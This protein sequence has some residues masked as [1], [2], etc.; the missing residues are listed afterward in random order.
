MASSCIPLQSI[1]HPIILNFN[2]FKTITVKIGVN[3][4]RELGA[5]FLLCACQPSIARAT[6]LGRWVR[7]RGARRVG[8]AE[9]EEGVHQ[10]R[11]RQPLPHLRV[12][13]LKTG[14]DDPLV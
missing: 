5:V 13:A 4:S 6:R 9:C 2:L 14:E 3:L 10:L 1:R 7:E 12:V 11:G 8:G